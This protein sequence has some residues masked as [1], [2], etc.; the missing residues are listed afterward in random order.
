MSKLTVASSPHHHNQRDTG[1]VMR[2]V[3]YAALPGIAVQTY[4]FGYGV[5]IQLLL[6]IVTAVVTEIAILELR[7]KNSERAFKDYSALL[8]ALLLAISIPPLAP[9]WVIVIGTFFSIAIV[10]QLYGGLGY[11]LFNPAMAGYVMLLI[12][13]PVQMT[14]WLPADSISVQSVSLWD[15]IHTVFT[16]YTASGYSIA[17]LQVTI[18]GVSS[19][20]PLDHVKTALSEGFV[21]SEALRDGSFS[22]AIG[23]GWGS[24]TLAYLL[25]GLLLIKTKVINWHI[26]ASMIISAFLCSA[27]LFMFDSSTHASPWFHMVNGSLIVGAFFIATDP[28]SAA[29]TNRGRIIFGAAIGFWII[30]IRTW[31]GYPDAIAFAVVLMNMAVPLIDYYTQPRT[32][33]HKMKAKNMPPKGD[34]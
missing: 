33:G 11:N 27:I 2:M 15:T 8:C 22:G 16:G 26:P 23:A 25:G 17:Q 28:V 12:S 7:G 30:V 31:G 6:A 4:M 14:S 10:K 20:T 18:D 1:A 34:V 3:V 21:I 9:W 24:V 32:Y 5:L 19:A 29:T 13:F